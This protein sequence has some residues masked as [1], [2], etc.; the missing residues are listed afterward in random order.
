MVWHIA[1]SSMQ[2][3]MLLCVQPFKRELPLLLTPFK[4]VE[5]LTTL[6]S[7]YQNFKHKTCRIATKIFLQLLD[8]YFTSP[9]L[10]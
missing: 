8:H 9:S 5:W 1:G 4:S 6:I 2:Q 10:S 3:L 7:A